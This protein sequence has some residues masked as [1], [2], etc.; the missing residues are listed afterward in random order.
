M[1][2]IASLLKRL[3]P[4]RYRPLKYL[5]RLTRKRSEG[6]VL[7]GPFAG[8]RYVDDSVEG[9]YIPKLLGIYEVELAGEVESICQRHAGLIVDIGAAEGYYAVG[10]AFRNP[11]IRIIAFEMNPAGQLALREMSSL[12][13][14]AERVEV[15][16]KCE[17]EDLIQALGDSPQPVVVCDA[18]GDESKLLDLQA[19]PALAK[20]SVL[21]ELHEFVIPG[22]AED[23]KRRFAATHR[24][25]Q[26][27]QQ[28]RSHRQFPWRTLGTALL[29]RSY[30][31]WGVSEWRP[32][33][34]A[35]L[36]M[37]PHA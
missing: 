8:M 27:W 23:L 16:G 36:W 4:A 26:I 37:E 34:M 24:I 11:N 9:A 25:K 29:P 2:P 22:I 21:V 28:P 10:L 12:N 30:L 17:P 32:E 6:R 35:W 18:E 19:V 31:E 3:I 13:H 1:N 33:R 14:V 20:A 7:G 5:Q 15:R